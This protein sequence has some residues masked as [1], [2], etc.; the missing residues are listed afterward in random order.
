MI[1]TP[2]IEVKRKVGRAKLCP[3][4]AVTLVACDPQKND[5]CVLVAAGRSRR[6]LIMTRVMLAVALLAVGVVAL[7]NGV[8][9]T[10]AMGYVLSVCIHAAGCWRL[11]ND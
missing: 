2:Q 7:D 4:V 9:R 8:G 5:W 10:P 1:G 3:R 6:R 11:L